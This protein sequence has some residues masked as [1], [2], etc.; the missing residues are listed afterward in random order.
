MWITYFNAHSAILD[1]ATIYACGLGLA[2][3]ALAVI[4]Y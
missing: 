2:L 4:V 1:L 3:D